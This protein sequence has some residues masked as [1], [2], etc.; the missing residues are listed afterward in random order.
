M[1]TKTFI[2]VVEVWVPVPGQNMLEHGGGIYNGYP[3]FESL[4]RDMCFGFGEGLPGQAWAS[5]RPVVLKQFEG[6]GF[7]R[8]AAAHALGL[9][10]GI[11][12]P[13]FTGDTLKAVVVI[14]CGDDEAHAGAI[15][16]WHNDPGTGP[17]MR[18]DDGYYGTTADIFEFM[19]RHTSFRK[20]N[21]LPGLAWESK[22]PVFMPDLGKGTRFMRSDSAVKV[23]INRGFA[24]PCS[25]RGADHFVMTFLS[26][27]ATP[28]VRRFETWRPDADGGRL[29]RSGGFCES[30]GVLAAGSADDRLAP[31]EGAIGRAWAERVP[32]VGR[33]APGEPGGVGAAARAAGWTSVVAL[34]V[35]RDPDVGAV[36]AWYF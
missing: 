25:V 2:R 23:G 13:I 14:F 3:R 7:R 36:V 16:L 19:S 21:G 20:G 33:D 10:C 22:L 26:A 29:V 4:S 8:T 17:D 35:I 11:A 9:T 30:Q 28:L 6:S 27:L 24:I 32:M 1:T 34:P 15:E 31:G 5:G 12:L 18:L